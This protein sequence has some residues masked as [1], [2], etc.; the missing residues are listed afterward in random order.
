ME[1]NLR[2]MVKSDLESV[3]KIRNDPDTYNFL[4]TP[5]PFT[6][7]EASDWFDKEKPM[8]YIIETTGM[9]GYIR[10]SNWNYE[11]RSIWI[12]CDIATSFRRHGIAFAAYT[13][14]LSLLK[15]VGWNTVK[16]SVLKINHGAISLYKKLGFE[17][18]EET[19][20][21]FNMKLQVNSHIN[22]GKGAKVI[23]CYFGNRRFNSA[24]QNPETASQAYTMLEFTWKIEQEVDQGYPHDTIFVHNELLPSDPCSSKEEVE[25]CKQFLNNINGKLTKNGKAIV[26]HRPNTG[27]SFAAFDHAHN[28]FKNYYDFFMF[29]EDDQVIVR[30]QVYKNGLRQLHMP[31]DVANGF[32][33]T[34]GVNYSWGMAANGGCGVTSREILQKVTENNF[35]ASLNRGSLPFREV[36]N[37]GHGQIQTNDGQCLSGEIAFTNIIHALGFYLEEHDMSD[38]NISWTDKRFSGRRTPRCHPFQDWMEDVSLTKEQIVQRLALP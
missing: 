2:L 19:S 4:H 20:D 29:T 25:K 38:I 34:V 18:Y 33:A 30:S 27:I 10:T 28:M 8:W 23:A 36:G 12:G 14:F 15:K 11:N 22:T 35:C 24:N 26:V 32:V 31:K 37:L 3:L 16:L 1:V 21:T 17:T 7:E 5:K 9:A 13:K 6:I